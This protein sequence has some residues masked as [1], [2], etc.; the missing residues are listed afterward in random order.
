MTLTSGDIHGKKLTIGQQHL[1]QK[2]RKFSNV[3]W[4]IKKKKDKTR[5]NKNNI[6]SEIGLS[7]P[8]FSGIRQR[9]AVIA[10]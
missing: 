2:L 10:F 7:G 9:N 1:S 3:C 6:S 4:Q 8:S 5:Q